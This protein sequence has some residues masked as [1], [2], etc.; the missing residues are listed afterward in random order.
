MLRT[1]GEEVAEAYKQRVE[2]TPD[3]FK[4]LDK[5]FWPLLPKN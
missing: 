3:R 1:G 2:V 4:R 5:S